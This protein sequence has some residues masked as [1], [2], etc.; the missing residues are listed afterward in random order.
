MMPTPASHKNGGNRAEEQLPPAQEKFR[1]MADSSPFM[2]WVHDAQ[3]GLEF[4][5]RAY[6]E[7]F[8][9]TLEEVSGPNWRPLVHPE[10]AP[11]YIDTF[12]DSLRAKTSWKCEARVRRA[13]GEWR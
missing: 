9:V 8:G 2:I 10:D 5:N 4:V 11:T 7:F 13:D 1:L 3:G 6:C 12:L